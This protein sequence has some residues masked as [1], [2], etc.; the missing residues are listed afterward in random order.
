MRR[1]SLLFLL[2]L[3]ASL[4]AQDGSQQPRFETL[5]YKFDR[6][7]ELADFEPLTGSW[8]ISAGSLWCTSKG[9]REELRW[10]RAVTA[11][12]SATLQLVGAGRVALALRSGQQETLIRLDRG[13]GRVAIEADGQPLAERPFEAKA[14]GALELRVH[15]ELDRLRVTVGD[16]DAFITTRPDARAPFDALSLL[17]QKS[18]PRFESLRLEREPIADPALNRAGGALTE[19]QKVAIERATQLLAADDA[20]D[21]LDQLRSALGATPPPAAEW[22]PAF[23]LTLQRV[24]L[25]R[26]GL[27]QRE[28]FAPLVASRALA[29]ADDSATLTLPL[30]PGWSGAAAP[31]RRADGPVFTASCADPPLTVE[32][33]RYDQKLKYWFGRDPRLVYSSGGGGAT[34][35]RA[36]RRAAGSPRRRHPGARVRPGGTRTRRREGVGVRALLAR[37]R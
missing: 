33:Y 1:R 26:P 14:L 37:P 20:G 30:R 27:L 18:Q 19:A 2:P 15:W 25:R 11:R 12:G 10:R 9:A 34:L 22:P 29:A 32:I 21:A 16:D 23:L 7:T 24:G 36:R 28:P 6:E 35:G 8:T 13:A 4:P 3:A 31:I 17:S 5:H